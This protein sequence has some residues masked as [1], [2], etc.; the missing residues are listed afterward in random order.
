[1]DDTE[2]GG[3]YVHA[4]RIVKDREESQKLLEI[5]IMADYLFV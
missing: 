3:T 2:Y 5:Y 1:M 4:K